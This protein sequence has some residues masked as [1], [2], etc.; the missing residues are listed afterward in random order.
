[1]TF[2]DQTE[3][4][5]EAGK[6]GDGAVSFLREKY[7]PKGGP[8]GGD[9]GNGGKIFF[10]STTDVVSLTDLDRKHYFKAENGENGGKNRCKGKNGEDTFLK[11]PVGTIVRE[12]GKIIHDFT[13]EN[14]AQVVVK[15]GQGGWGNW[16]FKTS[17]KQSPEWSK[18]GLNGEKKILN[19]ELKLIADVGII[20]LPN[21]GKS[22][23][24]STI[25]NARPKIAD[26]PFT[27]LVPNLGVVAVGEK[28]LVFADIPGLIEGAHQGKGLGIKF[29]RH[30]E[31]TKIVVHLISAES[32]DPISDYKII[33]NELKSFSKAL[34]KKQEIIVLSKSEILGEKELINKIKQIKKVIKKDILDISAVTGHNVSKLLYIIKEASNDH[35]S[36][37]V[38]K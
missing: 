35:E 31:R 28:S 20:G 11:V 27:T 9:G 12:N 7:R 25:S 3:I 26:Y 17:I 33:R 18:K 2:L 23:L 24:L 15:G 38:Q 36:T 8:D 16:H 10:E 6:G 13:Q 30:V 37:N 4:E 21:A 34:T 14:E 22:T 5:V 29:L 32:T 1:M 19:L